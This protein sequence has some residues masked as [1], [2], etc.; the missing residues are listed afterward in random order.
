M[1]Y[2][3][4]QLAGRQKEVLCLPPKGHIV[5]LGTAGSGKTTL[6]ILRALYLAHPRTEHYGSTLLVTFNKCLVA[7]LSSLTDLTL[8]DIDVLNY[9][10]FA[11]GYLKRRGK[12][13]QNCICDSACLK[14]LCRRAV[15]EASAAGVRSRILLRPNELLAEEF[16]WLAQHGITTFA[17]YVDAERVGRAGTRIT[18]NDRPV[19]FDLYERYKQLREKGEMKYDWDDLSHSVLS[20]F[21]AD[22]NPRFYR[23]V[24]IDEGQDFSP[25]MLKS[26][27]AAVPTNGSL[28]F[29]GDMAQ[30]VYG[31][32]MSWRSAGLRA[33][34]VF[35]NLR[36]TIGTPGRLPGLLSRLPGCR[37]S[38]TT[39]ISSCPNHPRRMV[40]SQL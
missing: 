18:K 29:F 12:M 33:F 34:K 16:R 20:E 13:R 4:P 25:M 32:R 31:N 38:P 40:R 15:A 35:G 19:V 5:V 30:Q 11:W 6:A 14:S 10:K 9:H 36:T 24:V 17:D 28:T 1:N 26:L 27:A 23:H 7:Y 22:D 3:L 8:H 39:L 37:T 21:D 2:E